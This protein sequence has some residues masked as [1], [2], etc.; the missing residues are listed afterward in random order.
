MD[1]IE[2]MVGLQMHRRLRKRRRRWRKERWTLIIYHDA[3]VPLDQ[4]QRD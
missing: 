3:L 1:R 2:L 4:T